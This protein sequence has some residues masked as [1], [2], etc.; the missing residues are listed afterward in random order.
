M[1]V[2][3]MYR[4]RNFNKEF[5]ITPHEQVLIQDLELNTLFDT[6][7]NGDKIIG[8]V[9]KKAF[10]ESLKNTDEILYR[11]NIL[12]D[13]IKNPDIIKTLYD[14]AT[15]AIERKKE[16]WWG[17]SGMSLSSILN[18]SVQLLQ[19]FVEMMRKIRVVVDEQDG[20][21]HSEG[22]TSLF[23]LLKKELNDD[24][25]STIENNLKELEFKKGILISAKLGNYNQGVHY[26]LSQLFC[27]ASVRHNL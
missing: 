13:C 1:K 18:S 25:L 16:N 8:E 23:S 5:K 11:Q 27:G 4:D 24:Y 2:H 14:I 17:V 6:M 19:M 21:F 15:T 22:F 12:K 3:L 7:A 20:K 10:F 26:V 9:A